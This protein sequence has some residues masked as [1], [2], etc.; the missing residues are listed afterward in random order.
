MNAPQPLT[1]T[2]RQETGLARPRCTAWA[3][4]LV[5]ALFIALA[6]ALLP[7]SVPASQL[8]GSA[9][10]PATT[11][12]ALSRDE[13]ERQHFEAPSD[14]RSRPTSPGGDTD[15]VVPAAIEAK[16]AAYRAT[17]TILEPV[18]SH[19][20]VP[21]RRLHPGTGPRAPPLNDVTASAIPA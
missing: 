11:S 6:S 2:S 17:H 15:A 7:G 1:D 21:A 19:H 3:C 18:A 13:S 12:V 5:A 4:G 14:D 8:V 9:F 16:V 10:N 20:G